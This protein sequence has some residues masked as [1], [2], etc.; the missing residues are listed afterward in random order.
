MKKKPDETVSPETCDQTDVSENVKSVENTEHVNTDDVENMSTKSDPSV[1]TSSMKSDAGDDNCT[2]T[3]NNETCTKSDA[4]QNTGEKVDTKDSGEKVHTKDNSREK[5]VSDGDDDKGK[6]KADMSVGV[7][8]NTKDDMSAD[9]ESDMKD[10]MSVGCGEGSNQSVGCGE[11][12]N[13]SAGC[14]E[15]SNQSQ[16]CGEKSDVEEDDLEIGKDNLGVGSEGRK[17]NP[18]LDKPEIDNAKSVDENGNP[19]ISP[20]VVSDVVNSP[21]VASDCTIPYTFSPSS[22]AKSPNQDP[23]VLLLLNKAIS[24]GEHEKWQEKGTN[25]FA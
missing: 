1:E 16:D 22:P 19:T 8:T 13:Q 24:S 25:D 20:D 7:K 14:G 2:K 23:S 10:D 9:V 11:G 4:L 17:P 15:G 3:D 6:M 12:S 21:D 5:S 18:E